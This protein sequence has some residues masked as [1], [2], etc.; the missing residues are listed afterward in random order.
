MSATDTEMKALREAMV[1]EIE[2]SAADL[3]ET[4]GRGMLSPRVMAALRDVPRHLFLPPEHLSEAYLN[5]P[6]PI[7][8][9]QTISQPFIV[10][11]MT[12]LLDPRPS[13]R[14]LEVGTGS[15]YQTAVLARLAGTVF[16]V[17]L[18]A[19]LAERA[20]R[21]FAELGLGGI[22]T[23]VGDGYLGWPEEAPFDAILVAAAPPEV[24]EPL[25]R[26]LAPGGRL[27]IPVGREAQQ[28]IVVEKQSDQSII[29]RE[30]I[31]VC[32]VP[33]RREGDPPD[34]L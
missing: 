30:I 18:R 9:G 32:F 27:A 6:V 23:R 11:L 13:H 25:I 15:G 24:P 20:R 2:L 14:V 28:L 31:P 12:D 17:E 34:G 5:R 1:R 7:G 21:V 29:L 22:H 8:H 16:T 4:L 3:A 10:A 19:P 26:Q 33:L